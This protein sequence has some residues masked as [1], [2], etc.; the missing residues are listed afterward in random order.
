[1]SSTNHLILLS[2]QAST[3][4]YANQNQNLNTPQTVYPQEAKDLMTAFEKNQ[5]Q[6]QTKKQHMDKFQEDK[7]KI[8]EL[9]CRYWGKYYESGIQ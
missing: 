8:N 7:V 9:K 5:T 3:Q 6:K 2:G 4:Q 1:M